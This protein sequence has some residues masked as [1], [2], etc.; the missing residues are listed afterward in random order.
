M[1]NSE[2]QR[3]FSPRIPGWPRTV[4]GVEVENPLWLAPLAGIT[5]GSFRRFHRML[6][7]GLVHTE[8]VSA[9]RAEIQGTQ[10]ERASAWRRG[11]RALACS[12][13]SGRERRGHRTRRGDRAG[14]KEFR[15]AGGQ[16][17]LPDA[18]GHKKGQRFEADGKSA[19][20]GG[21]DAPSESVWPARL[22]KGTHHAAERRRTDGG[23]LRKTIQRRR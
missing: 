19:G 22:G 3:P 16:Y 14:D 13:S 8:M 4:G 10:D 15:G 5:F 18:Q 23:L 20:G 6:G 2:N 12:S 9:P 21:D 1:E 11:R 7:A 17:G